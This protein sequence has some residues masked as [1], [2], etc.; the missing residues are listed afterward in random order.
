VARYKKVDMDIRNG[1]HRQLILQNTS[2]LYG[3]HNYQIKYIRNAGI[4]DKG[5]AKKKQDPYIHFY[6]IEHEEAPKRKSIHSR[7]GHLEN[8]IQK[9]HIRGMKLQQTSTKKL[10]LVHHKL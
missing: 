4:C 3:E 1:L 9:C 8:L 5:I 10:Q 2:H 7:A 6:S